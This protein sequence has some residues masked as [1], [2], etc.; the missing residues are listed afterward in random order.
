MTN[1]RK[2]A[3]L[4]LEAARRAEERAAAG[5][6]AADR[7]YWLGIAAENRARATQFATAAANTW[8]RQHWQKGEPTCSLN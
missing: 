5:H 2:L 7:E 4:A 1:W 8:N 6:G 3:S